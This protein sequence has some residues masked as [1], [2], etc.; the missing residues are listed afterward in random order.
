MVEIP[1]EGPRFSQPKKTAF[2]SLVARIAELEAE[3]NK[4]LRLAQEFERENETLR[5]LLIERDGGTHDADC[6]VHNPG[7]KRCNCG[8]AEV[9]ELRSRLALDE[10][11]EERQE[12][13]SLATGNSLD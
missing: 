2:G 4:W 11:L 9:V 3:N 7:I 12:M 8:H 10:L 6:K 5:E 1:Y 13:E